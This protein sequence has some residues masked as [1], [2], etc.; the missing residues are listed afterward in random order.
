MFRGEADPLARS[1]MKFA[2]APAGRD[3]ISQCATICPPFVGTA[4]KLR[5]GVRPAITLY[6]SRL[7][8]REQCI[9]QSPSLLSRRVI[10]VPCVCAQDHA[11]PSITL[12]RHHTSTELNECIVEMCSESSI[13]HP[14]THRLRSSET[15]SQK[16]F[17][18]RS[19]GGPPRTHKSRNYFFKIQQ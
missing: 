9:F 13:S 4:S 3:L 7:D 2:S 11:P 5:S 14:A 6:R 19:K 17:F 10:R 1:A 8:H 12:I 18:V 15:Q 16:I